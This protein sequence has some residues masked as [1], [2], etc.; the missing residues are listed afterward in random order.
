V[1]VY[2]AH[3]THV[4]PGMS[5]EQA[6][7]ARRWEKPSLAVALGVVPVLIAR[8]QDLLGI[9]PEIL[10]CLITAFLVAEAARMLQLAPDNREWLRRNLLDVVVIVAA[11]VSLPFFEP[12]NDWV[13]VILLLRVLDLLPLVHRHVIRVTPAL[14]AFTLLVVVWLMGALAFVQVEA[15]EGGGSYTLLQGLYWSMTTITTVG[16]GDLSP[17]TPTGYVLTM[18]LE[19]V[20]LGVGALIVAAAVGFFNREF[21]EAFLGRVE[22]RMDDLLPTDDPYR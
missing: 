9:V 1:P 4:V 12:G 16:Y 2:S 10:F 21:A 3:G 8:Q 15:P 6:A 13:S 11:L 18:I 5:D 14:F 22:Q 17:S 7:R 19:P 20:G